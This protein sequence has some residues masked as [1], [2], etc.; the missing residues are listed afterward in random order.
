MACHV[1]SL[2]QMLHR[3]RITEYDIEAE[4]PGYTFTEDNL[5]RIQK[6]ELSIT[7]TVPEDAASQA[8]RCLD[9]YEKGCVVGET[10]KR[11]Q[12]SGRQRTGT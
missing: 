8:E 6:L 5:K 1:N 7:L 2:E 3:A 11:G 4:S 9:I 10:L 12:L